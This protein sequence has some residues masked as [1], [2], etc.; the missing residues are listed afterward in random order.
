M[1]PQSIAAEINAAAASACV[2]LSVVLELSLRCNEQCYYCYRSQESPTAELSANAWA[3]I[4]RQ[5]AQAGTLYC[6]ITG[7]EPFLRSDLMEILQSAR[8]FDLAISI[9]SNGTLITEEHARQLHELGIMDVGISLL[10]ATP[11]LH[12]RLSGMDGSFR[13]ATAALDLLRRAGVRTLIKH[14]VS[15]ENFGHYRMLREYAEL[16]GHGFEC[17]TMIMPS[18]NGTPSP[19]ALTQSQHAVFMNDMQM[20]HCHMDQR[21]ALHCDAGRSLCG[22]GPAGD[23]YP[24]ILLPQRWG[25]LEDESFVSL[26]RGRSAEQFR[27]DEENV[28]RV[29]ATC[30]MNTACARCHALALAE[31]GDWRGGA[32]SLC[33]RAEAFYKR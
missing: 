20:Q 28:R 12:D 16:H 26:W 21:N 9:L 6:T 33:T 25:S 30:E 14:S 8:S 24:C 5:L 10:A 4:F 18:E 27:R 32:P 7:G 23:L 1:R 11:E 15:S 22:I 17:D 13:M 3:A 29:C 19:F 31:T 2:P